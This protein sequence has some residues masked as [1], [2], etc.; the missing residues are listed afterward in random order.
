MRVIEKKDL[1]RIFLRS[2][3]IQG[4]WNYQ[5]MLNLG[6][7]YAII[8]ILHK[9]YNNK[10]DRTKFLHRHLEFFN[11]HPYF[12]SF[13]LGAT[14][15]LE[16]QNL[17]QHWE[18]DKPILMLKNRLCGPLGAMGDKL[19]WGTV[20]PLAAMIGVLITLFFGLAGPV[21]LFV[22]YNVPHIYLRYYGIMRGY[23]LG[24]DI[25]RELSKRKF[26]KYTNIL[27]KIGILVAGIFIGMFPVYFREN[28]GIYL[29]LFFFIAMIITFPFIRRKKP[30]I[31]P[32]IIN[33]ALFLIFSA[34]V[35]F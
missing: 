34:F 33:L 23:E 2:F 19:F 4:S 31:V 29:P 10:E 32:I 18:S 11:A 5:R 22:L 24:F 7:C 30:I 1:W 17:H 8:P 21:V 27:Q 16:E 26:E 3:Y 25:V 15:R 12:A 20:K 14:T 13:A 35:G 6:F 28:K 9:L